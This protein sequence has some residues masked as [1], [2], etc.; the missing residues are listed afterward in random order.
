MDDATLKSGLTAFAT[1]LVVVDPFDVLPIFISLA[2][3]RPATERSGIATRAV[4]LD[5]MISL[6]F[7]VAGHGA[8]AFLGVLVHAFSI[9]GGILLFITALPMLFGQR[10]ALQS[11]EKNESGGTSR[12]FHSPSHCL[13]VQ[14]QLRAFS[15]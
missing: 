15:C 13:P 1:L 14:A 5:F 11:A 2:R 6:F 7:L 10:P 9:S 12:F 4:L 3:N 8:L